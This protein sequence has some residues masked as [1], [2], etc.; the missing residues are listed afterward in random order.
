M[1]FWAAGAM[2]LAGTATSAYGQHS[3]NQTNREIAREQMQFQ[4]RMSNTAVQRRMADL[5]AAG[6]N[7]ILAGRYDASTP[8]GAIATMGNV[9]A[10]AVQGGQAAL[11]SALAAK[12][13]KANIALVQQTKDLKEKQTQILEPTSELMSTLG[14]FLRSTKRGGAEATQGGLYNFIRSSLTDLFEAG[15]VGGLKKT[16]NINSGL[17]VSKQ[18]IEVQRLE[19]ALSKMKKAENRYR[20]MDKISQLDRKNWSNLRNQIDINEFELKILKQDLK[21]M[22][23]Q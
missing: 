19:Q 21:R 18:A 8:P 5:Q 16:E 10:S 15:D 12:Q 13:A 7:P 14:D 22:Q 1:P 11:S 17:D 23:R 4:E 20:S 2:Y 6:I 3:A 9:G